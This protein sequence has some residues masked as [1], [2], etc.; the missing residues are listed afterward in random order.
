MSPLS[1]WNCIRL[2]GVVTNW[3]ENAELTSIM[4]YG[5]LVKL[6]FAPNVHRGNNV[7]AH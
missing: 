4:E 1:R 2:A 7:P 5:E 6:Q 3:N